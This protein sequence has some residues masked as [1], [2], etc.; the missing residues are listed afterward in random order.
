MILQLISV[1]F[2]ENHPRYSPFTVLSLTVTFL[3]CQ[4]ASFV[5]SSQSSISRFSIYWKEYFPFIFTLRSF[6]SWLSMNKY[7]DTISVSTSVISCDFHPNSC[8]STWQRSRRMCS[9]SRTALIPPSTQSV[10]LPFSAY[11]IAARVLSSMEE[12]AM[13]NPF[14][15]HRG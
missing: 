10:I 12:S 4:N 3:L 11:Q 9:H 6:T 7:S 8:D 2:S 13:V 5:S 15:C 1:R 14:T